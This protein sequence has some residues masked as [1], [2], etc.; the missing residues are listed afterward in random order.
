MM[1]MIFSPFEQTRKRKPISRDGTMR[2]DDDSSED[3]DDDHDGDIG[4]TLVGL[5]WCGGDD[6]KW[7]SFFFASFYTKPSV[8]FLMGWLK[9]KE[10]YN[11]NAFVYILPFS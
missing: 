6:G 11:F 7:G 10:R 2:Y 9:L 3:G 5:V 8:F 1:M 4:S